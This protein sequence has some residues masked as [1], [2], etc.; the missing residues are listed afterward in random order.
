ML[1]PFRN[2]KRSKYYGCHPTG[3]QRNQKVF[4][5]EKN[6]CMD[7]EYNTLYLYPQKGC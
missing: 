3:G 1:E 5:T 7:D 4:I 2:V 6:E